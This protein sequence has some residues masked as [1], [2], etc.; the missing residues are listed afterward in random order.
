MG[1]SFY[2]KSP[3]PGS[4]QGC[5]HKFAGG[6]ARDHV[7]VDKKAYPDLLRLPEGF[8]LGSLKIYGT[9]FAIYLREPID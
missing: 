3:D 5:L 8:V 6:W 4:S 2:G 1:S 7:D 9:I